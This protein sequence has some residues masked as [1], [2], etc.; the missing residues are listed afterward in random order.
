MKGILILLTFFTTVAFSQE[1]EPWKIVRINE[2]RGLDSL[3]GMKKNQAMPIL[4]KYKP[5][6]VGGYFYKNEILK[7]EN[8]NK[9]QHTATLYIYIDSNDLVYKLN[10]FFTDGIPK[11]IANSLED[12]MW[13]AVPQRIHTINQDYGS[14]KIFFSTWKGYALQDNEYS[15]IRRLFYEQEKPIVKV[16]YTVKKLNTDIINPC[17]GN[18]IYNDIYEPEIFD[19]N[20]QCGDTTLHH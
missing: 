15:E 6:V 13:W 11:N 2:A 19:P 10:Y 5:A 12:S 1:I 16:I 14:S 20:M 17:T 18:V 8:F 9:W 4:A 7:I 3:L